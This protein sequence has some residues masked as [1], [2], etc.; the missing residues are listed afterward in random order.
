MNLSPHARP[1]GGAHHVDDD[2]N[3]AG[4][5]NTG[6]GFNIHW[7][8][9]PIHDDNPRNGAFVEEVLEA[10][11]DRLRY[12]N[13]ASDGRFRCRENSLAITDIE[14]AQNWL[15]R[16]TYDRMQR[17]VEGTHQE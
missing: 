17:G 2:G 7:Q 3:P 16:R 9:G 15:N 11:L 13:G 10:C 1:I 4:G 12:L 6:V 5:V 14:S 8:N